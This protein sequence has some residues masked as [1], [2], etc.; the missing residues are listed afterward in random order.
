MRGT[1]LAAALLALSPL[2][3]QPAAAQSNQAAQAP[4]DSATTSP[5]AE[6]AAGELV[7]VMHL[8]QQWPTMMAN[9]VDR[10]IANQPQMA[11][12]R[13]TMLEFMTK[14][15]GW[16]TV[17]PV[18]Q[19]LYA[20]QFTEPE[21]HDLLVFYRTPTGQKSVAKIP[22]LQEQGTAMGE[23]LVAA[24]KDELTAAIVARTQQIR[25]SAYATPSPVGGTVFSKGAGTG[26]STGA[27]TGAQTSP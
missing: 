2:A 24:H 3:A 10:M 27:S 22:A 18:L 14:Y 13:Q 1:T 16:Q 15:V 7:K 26:A 25:D 5:G 19:H 21:L 23:Q 20:Q 6:R 12:Y 9:T 8:D 4:Q 11:P 17:E